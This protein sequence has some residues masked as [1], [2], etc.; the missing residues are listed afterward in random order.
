[1]IGPWLLLKVIDLP[2][3]SMSVPVTLKGGR[4]FPADLHVRL[5]RLTQSDQI[6]GNPR[7]GFWRGQ[8]RP[9]HK[10]R[11]L[12]LLRFY[13]PL[14][15]PTAV[16]V[17]MSGVQV[18]DLCCLCDLM[19]MMMM[20]AHTLWRRTSQVV[21]TTHVHEPRVLWAQPQTALHFHKCIALFVGDSCFFW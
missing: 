19:M 8:A 14:L 6:H 11:A 1:M 20:N 9:W 5:Y 10:R 13:Y 12:A 2:D 17:P 3:R 4:S 15:L 7:V 16:S 21:M 18:T